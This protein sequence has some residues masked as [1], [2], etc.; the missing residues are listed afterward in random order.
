VQIEET[1]AGAT[2]RSLCVSRCASFGAGRGFWVLGWVG[3]RRLLVGWRLVILML[4]LPGV[5]QEKQ[6]K[7][8][9]G[10]ERIG[11]EEEGEAAEIFPN[12]GIPS[13][14]FRF[15]QY[16]NPINQQ[17]KENHRHSKRIFFLSK[18]KRKNSFRG[19][20]GGRRG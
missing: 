15:L 16:R 2:D 12:P 18:S 14:Q 19:A 3:C 13:S 4:R 10:P 17:K 7:G 9:C 20:G 11:E 8:G 1:E 6:R 5:G